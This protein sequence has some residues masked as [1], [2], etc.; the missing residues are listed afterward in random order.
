M[1]VQ[2]ATC[3]RKTALEY[4]EK[5]YPSYTVTEEVAK[6]FLDLLEKDIIRLQDPFMY[7]RVAVVPGKNYK[8]EHQ[9][10]VMEAIKCLDDFPPKEGGAE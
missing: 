9:G 7:P 4:L 8:D 2:F 10:E 6:P 5:L 3:N 1:S